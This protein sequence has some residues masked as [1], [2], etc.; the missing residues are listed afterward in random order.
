MKKKI[1]DYTLI[2]DAFGPMEVWSLQHP[3]KQNADAFLLPMFDKRFKDK[4]LRDV[5][6]ATQDIARH[7]S[8]DA[9]VMAYIS[10]AVEYHRDK[11]TEYRMIDN[12]LITKIKI[13]GDV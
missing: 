3:I 13:I 9:I 4:V 1:V 8:P 2:A 7:F 11:K 5:E 6:K 12:L 10:G